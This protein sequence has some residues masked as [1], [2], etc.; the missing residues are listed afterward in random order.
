MFGIRNFFVYT[1]YRGVGAGGRSRPVEPSRTP[2]DGPVI[3]SGAGA[4]GSV[5]R[6]LHVELWPLGFLSIGLYAMVTLLV[7][8]Y[9]RT[10]GM[11]SLQLGILA[12]AGSLLPMFFAFPCGRAC[13]A[14]GPRR[15]IALA[16][17][18]AAA[19]TLAFWLAQDFYAFLGLQ[20]VGGFARATCWMGAQAHVAAIGD[21]P[22]GRRRTIAFSFAAMAG[23][24]VTALAAGAVADVAGYGVAM[25]TAAGGYVILVGVALFLPGAPIEKPTG[26]SAAAMAV[27]LLRSRRMIVVLAATFLRFANGPLRLTFFPLY[28][29]GLGLS[30]AMIGFYVALGNLFGTIGAPLAGPLLS[31][32]GSNIL[33]HASIVLSLGTLA[34]T[35]LATG[36][37]GISV[38]S[39]L[40]G[41]GMGLSLPALLQETATA[42]GPGRRGAAMGLRQMVSEAAALTGPVLLGI[43]SASLGVEGGF[44]LVGGLLCALAVV[45]AILPHDDHGKSLAGS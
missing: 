6:D 34:L 24:L 32:V 11:P 5:F 1:F 12:G 26:Q 19:S 31:R 30:P 41:I 8:L 13:D 3:V 21:G 42:A 9:A 37:V 23:P 45:T 33:L 25:A 38:S 10:L 36:A 18:A 40:W 4:R 27:A 16:S 20:L 28:L 22:D 17:T 43:A 44:Y 39:V 7:P 14:V 35:P 15:I 29:V 2:I